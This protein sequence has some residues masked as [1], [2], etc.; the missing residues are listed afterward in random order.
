MGPP[1]HFAA[2][3]YST[4]GRTAQL[5]SKLCVRAALPLVWFLFVKNTLKS[6]LTG[7]VLIE[8]IYGNILIELSTAHR[9][10]QDFPEDDRVP[11]KA[12]LIV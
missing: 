10:P 3:E 2:G 11:L 7:S 9:L 1:S 12:R 4:S 5:G 6:C 8:R